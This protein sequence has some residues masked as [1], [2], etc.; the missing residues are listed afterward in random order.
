MMGIFCQNVT[1]LFIFT[2]LKPHS[3][4]FMTLFQIH[5]LK[6]NV[7]IDIHCIYANLNELI[8]KLLRLFDIIKFKHFGFW[9][10]VLILYTIEVGLNMSNTKLHTP[11]GPG[12]ILLSPALTLG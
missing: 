7:L 1:S 3:D 5:F 8:T 2:F 12:P 11:I 4:A 10:Q 9:R 6:I